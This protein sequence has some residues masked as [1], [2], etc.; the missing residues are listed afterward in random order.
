MAG[1]A[2]EDEAIMATPATVVI[3]ED[4]QAIA[5]LLC[6]VLVDAGYVS[7]C[8]PTAI[9]AAEFI[10]EVG[11]D[12]VLLDVMMPDIS[13]WAVLDE[14][15]ANPLTRETPVVIT[16]AVYDRPGL[17]SLPPG[18]P[19]RFAAKPFDIVTLVETV[20]ELIA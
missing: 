17:H 1:S 16:S 4:Q 5:E 9:G 11:A 19:I 18:G 15:R 3:V 10:R 20:N 13:G 7:H 12:L 8:A 2:P 14:L 6:E